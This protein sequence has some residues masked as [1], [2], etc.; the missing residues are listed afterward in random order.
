MI[1]PMLSRVL[2][3]RVKRKTNEN[4]I[5]ECEWSSGRI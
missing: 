1:K 4:H 5:L 2:D 3:K